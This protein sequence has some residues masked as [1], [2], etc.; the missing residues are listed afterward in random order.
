MQQMSDISDSYQ[1]DYS[2]K[3][4][5]SVTMLTICLRAQ[6]QLP[7]HSWHLAGQLNAGCAGHINVIIIIIDI[8]ASSDEL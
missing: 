7:L 4:S 8:V 3:L 2:V 1:I 5:L 6:H